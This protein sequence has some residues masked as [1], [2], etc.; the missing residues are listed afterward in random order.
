MFRKSLIFGLFMLFVVQIPAFTLAS[1]NPEDL[2][3]KIQ[4]IRKEIDKN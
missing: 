4:K 1:G 3:A 2:V